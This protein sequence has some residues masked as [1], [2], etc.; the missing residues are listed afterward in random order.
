MT[1]AWNAGMIEMPQAGRAA[2]AP[3]NP[4]SR[5]VRTPEST[6]SGN[7]RGGVTCQIGPQKHTA[8]KGATLE[9]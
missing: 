9:G 8:L 6:A 2:A 4:V 7:T 1:P 3:G 5:K